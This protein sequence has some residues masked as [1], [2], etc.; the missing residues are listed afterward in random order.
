MFCSV[1]KS[2]PL[3]VTSSIVLVNSSLQSCTCNFLLEAL[4]LLTESILLVFCYMYVHTTLQPLLL[5]LHCKKKS[6]DSLFS[7]T[8]FVYLNYAKH[9]A[10][11]LLLNKSLPFRRAWLSC[12]L[13][14]CFVSVVNVTISPR[15]IVWNVLRPCDWSN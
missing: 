6:L 14:E 4:T 5:I 10:T 12:N 3:S 15:P 9:T 7:L 8:P 11:S 13:G 2:A 1:I